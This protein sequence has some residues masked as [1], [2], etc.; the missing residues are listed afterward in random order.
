MHLSPQLVDLATQFWDLELLRIHASVPGICY[1]HDCM[2]SL[3]PTGLHPAATGHDFLMIPSVNICLGFER[4]A[5]RPRLPRLLCQEM[6]CCQRGS[7]PVGVIFSPQQLAL[8][9]DPVAGCS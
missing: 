5:V 4:L 7:G 6:C 2:Y 3:A 8:P 1:V 9:G